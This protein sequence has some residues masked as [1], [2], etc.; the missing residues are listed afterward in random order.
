[1]A[2]PMDE[3]RTAV[4]GGRSL[5]FA[6]PVAGLA[7]GVVMAASLVLFAVALGGEPTAA[8]EPMGATFAGAD[9][10]DGGAGR[11]P[12]GLFLH[13]AVSALFGLLFGSV[14]PRA[15]PPGNAALLCVGFAFFVLGVMTS[16]VVPAVNPVLEDRFHDHGGSWVVAHA[17]FGATAGYVCQWLRQGSPARAARQLR[18]RTS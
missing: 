2:V 6:G 17:L 13:L 18:P 9:V 14:L 1:M 10:P 3:A 4:R 7:G 12:F 15:F 16:V 11:L 8:L 5:V